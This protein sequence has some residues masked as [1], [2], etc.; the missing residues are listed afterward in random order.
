[1]RVAIAPVEGVARVAVRIYDPSGRRIADV[2][3]ASVFPAV[4]LW[5]GR[6]AGGERVRSGILVLACESFASDGARVGVEK[7][8]VGCANR[9][10]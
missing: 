5:D 8:V 3:T 9:S 6:A 4:L 1:M 10:P 7:V 2:G